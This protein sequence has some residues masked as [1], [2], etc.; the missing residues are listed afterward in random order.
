MENRQD[1]PSSIPDELKPEVRLKFDQ[2]SQ[3]T[4]M[5]RTKIYSL[6]KEGKFP[7]PERFGKRSSRWRAATLVEF[8]NARVG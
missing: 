2:V 1:R 5:G 3:I 4:G 6:I 7:E 8:L